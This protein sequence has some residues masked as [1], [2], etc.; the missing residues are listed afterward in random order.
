MPGDAHQPNPLDALLER[1][2]DVDDPIVS[3]WA[4]G[5]LESEEAGAQEQ[6]DTNPTPAA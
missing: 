6:I 3:A 5:L 1:L 2:A 4:A